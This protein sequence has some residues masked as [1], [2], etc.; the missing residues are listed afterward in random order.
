LNLYLD[1]DS[2]FKV[3]EAHVGGLF[4]TEDCTEGQLGAYRTPLVPPF[5]GESEGINFLAP[6]PSNRERSRAA[7]RRPSF[8]L[9]FSGRTSAEDIFTWL[10]CNQKEKRAYF[11]YKICWMTLPER[12]PNGSLNFA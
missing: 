1:C 6:I 3:S 7:I 5:S 8:S 9:Y 10:R 4:L 11:I 2:T 12:M